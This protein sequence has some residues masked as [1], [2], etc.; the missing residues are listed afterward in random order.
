M[1]LLAVAS[2]KNRALIALVTICSLIFGGIALQ[3]LRT[4][5]A[6]DIEF[7]Q[8]AVI[9][10]Y[11][12]A[13][14]E[15]VAADVT[16]TIE[17]ALQSIPDLKQTQGTSS[18]GSATVM[19]EFEFG[20]PLAT[21][22][23]KVQQSIS[24]VQGALPDGVTTN[25]ISGSISDFPIIQLA[26]S[27]GEG[28][29][30]AL[31]DQLELDAIPRLE[32]LEGV[33]SVDLAGVAGQ[34]VTIVADD[35]ALAAAELTQADLA[36][37]IS[38]SGQL[39]PAGTIDDGDQTLSVQLGQQ[40]SSV[41][42][43]RQLP[44]GQVT[45]EDVAEV[46]LEASPLTSVSLVDGDQAVTISITKTPDANTVDV[47]YAV[48]ALLPELESLLGDEQTITVVFDQA[49]FISMSID[50][51]ATEGLLG[52]VMAIVVIL[53]FLLS[54]R[55]T[56][57]T[58]ISI[59]T[60]LLVTFIGMW[61]LDYTMNILTLG[62]LTIAI[63]RVV[64][65]SIVVVENI[66]R[67]LGFERDRMRAVLDGVREVAGAITASTVTT[68]VVFLP[69]AFVS[70]VAG[71]LFRP[72]AITSSVALAASLLVALTIV[73]VLSYWLLR[74]TAPEPASAATESEDVEPATAAP[75][76]LARLLR[77]RRTTVSASTQQRDSATVD[78]VLPA[79]EERGPLRRGYARILRGALRRPVAVLV[80]A[81]VIFGGSLG[82]VNFMGISFL[83]DSGE[84]A[85]RMTQSTEAGLSLERQTELARDA[86][87]RIQGVE[88]VETVQVTIGGGEF[89]AFGGGGGSSISYSI[90]AVEGSDMVVVSDALR[91]ATDDLEGDFALAQTGFASNDIQVDVQAAD[92]DALTEAVQ[93]VFEQ[94]AEVEEVT[95]VQ[96]G[97]AQQQPLVEVAVNRQAAA[98]RG[99]TEAQVVGAVTGAT[100]PRPLGSIQL[101]GAQI[102]LYLTPDQPPQTAAELRQLQV[103]TL[104][105]PVALTELADV[106]IVDAPSQ[107]T[108]VNSVRSA[109]VTAAIVGSDVGGA[110]AA[111]E[112]AL[113][114][115]TLPEGADWSIG[116]VT[117]ET[118][119][120][121]TQLGIA[122]LIAILLVY[123]VMVATFKSLLQPLLLLISV[124]FAA[125][126]AIILQLLSGIPLGVASMVGVLMLIGIVVTNAIVLVD[127]VNQYRNRGLSVRDAVE[128]GAERR[129][130]PILM[131]AA[132]TIFALVPL[133]LGVTGQGGFISQPLAIVVIGGLVSSTLL[134]LVVLPVLY[135]VVEGARERRRTRPGASSATRN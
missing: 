78:G 62:A 1:H 25:V 45:V 28:S 129:L 57:V 16:D 31:A 18:Q 8:L 52:L 130:R 107:V 125:T 46:T 36:D 94:V 101:E 22:E 66:K 42:D 76:G 128:A 11:E 67:H 44:V 49:P 33:R 6:P 93:L 63:G 65:D 126:G 116:G 112:E 37:A 100:Q 133:A 134:T 108:T 84:N 21:I 51:L 68:I 131:T 48:L 9:A 59:P 72:F 111:V 61:A 64:D 24:R 38:G 75:R 29:P 135:A 58:A 86:T 53:V 71:E 106:E 2:L 89:A 79:G 73:P 119:D 117:Q 118:T 83:G 41:D 82:L 110:S 104:T 55:S 96:S 113:A 99:L 74:S 109:A 103:P 98:E 20:T 105:G 69:L 12:G 56:F 34:R 60:S 81:A 4:E 114:E 23:Q 97:L 17:R 14:P 90:T 80:G 7:P 35:A 85:V 121:L 26:V 87:E 27:I 132:A 13:S 115:I 88:N 124:P 15:V 32:R 50:A 47:S 40:L 77:R 10:Q 54:I 102:I 123:I 91:E 5:L 127:L 122:A 19:A 39:S 92:P 3:S 30:E 43:I 95:Q 120:A 70:D